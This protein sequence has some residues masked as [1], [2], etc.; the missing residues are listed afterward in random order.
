MR[1]FIA[2]T[3]T[4][5][6]ISFDF[7]GCAYFNTF[8]LAKK[9]FSDGEVLRKRDKGKV[10]G[11]T[12]TRYKDAIE[13]SRQ[14]IEKYKNSK[15]VDDAL[16]IIGMS[17]YRQKNFT[18]AKVKFDEILAAFPDSK[19]ASDAIFYKAKCLIELDDM[20]EARSIFIKI[21]NSGDKK[22]DALAG[23]EI[24]EL[25]ILD[26]DWLDL[27]DISGNII[28]LNPG[29]KDVFN[30]N[31]Y[32]ARAEFELNNYQNCIDILT[33]Y[34]KEKLSTD[35]RFR[36]NTLLSSAYAELGNYDTAMNY[37]NSIGSKGKFEIY[38]RQIRLE[39]ANL[40]EIKGDEDLALDTYKKLAGDYPDS[41]EGKQAWY[42][43]GL[44]ILKDLSNAK[45][46][47]D[48]FDKIKEDTIVKT[49]PWYVDA[50]IKKVQIDS[51][52]SK[53]NLID[54]LSGK[55][56]RTKTGKASTDSLAK[57]VDAAKPDEKKPVDSTKS[58]EKKP[59]DS[60]KADEKKTV[61][62][63]A[64]VS[65]RFSLAEIYTYSFDRPDSA[66][67]QYHFIIEE[68]PGSEYAVKSE[69]FLG[70]NELKSSGKYS[71]ETE[72][73]LMKNIVAKHPKSQFSQELKVLLGEQVKTPE[74]M[75][76]LKA[77][78]AR[79]NDKKPEE[80]IPLYL[81]VAENNKGT[82]IAYQSLFIAAYCYEHNAGQKDKAYE[83][84]KNLS[85]EKSNSINKKYV[86]LAQ[87]KM[88][89]V[90]KEPELLAQI[91]KNISAFEFEIGSDGKKAISSNTAEE[92][93]ETPQ[94]NIEDSYPGL[95][96]IRA[97]NARIR[98]RY[99]TN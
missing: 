78:N 94:A 84:L 4:A 74:V 45:E 42:R 89:L 31:Y 33:K 51:M 61:D 52:L 25:D 62:Y 30:A 35:L 93:I 29:E 44:I 71:A 85:L 46:A 8:F 91:T 99:F 16:Y 41:L 58:D 79:M 80:Y 96:K 59:I 55:E 5:L 54:K 10:I 43:S 3:V 81:A 98:S 18:E 60:S 88:E 32:L 47:K 90:T 2:L 26:E 15:Y 97:R 82:E 50:Q 1:R 95:K 66:L 9:N 63:D 67:S 12:Q 28:G 53:I 36:I 64:I 72:K 40:Y 22:I 69:Y 86:K 65:T 17:Y 21:L 70:L 7:T 39:L 57:P 76:F 92:T 20:D 13:Y 87:D 73:E 75:D 23:F 77:E 68:S 83:I 37:L 24:C 48:N 34:D 49:E 11:A 56:V 6:I 38:S 14:V 27:K 19:F